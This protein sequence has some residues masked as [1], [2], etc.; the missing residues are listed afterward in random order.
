MPRSPRMESGQ[1]DGRSV[2]PRTSDTRRDGPAE[3]ATHPIQPIPDGV[4]PDRVRLGDERRAAARLDHALAV[5]AA[6]R[7]VQRSAATEGDAAVLV[8]HIVDQLTA[9]GSYRAAWMT[10]HDDA[11]RV[12]YVAQAGFG[13]AFA[14]LRRRLLE[15]DCGGCVAR[16]AAD[17]GPARLTPHDGLCQACP[18]RGVCGECGALT[19]ALVHEGRVMG[20]LT[21]A[22]RAPAEAI[23]EADVLF[24]RLVEDIALALD[25]AETQA[26]QRGTEQ[27]LHE[28]RQLLNAISEISPSLLYVYDFVEDRLRYANRELQAFL[29][30]N[31]EQAALVDLET[32]LELVHPEDRQEAY[33]LLDQLSTLHQGEH[34]KAELRVR[35]SRGGWHWLRIWL[36]VLEAGENGGPRRVL[37]TGVD[38]TEMRLSQERLARQSAEIEA[39]ANNLPDIVTRV[40][41]ALRY[42]FF[43]RRFQEVTGVSRGGLGRTSREVGLPVDLCGLLEKS[44][45]AVFATE[46]AAELDFSYVGV[47]G[48][49]RYHARLVPE[50]GRDGTVDTILLI[51]AD[52]TETRRAQEEIRQ[53]QEF[54]SA[55]VNGLSAQLA[56]LNTRGT[57]VAVNEAWRRFARD[58][59]LEAEHFGIGCNYLEVCRA[60]AETG[61]SELGAAVAGIAAVIAGR[62]AEYSFEY[63]CHRPGQPT[64]AYWFLMRVTH[65]RHAGQTWGV[66]THVDITDRRLAEDEVRKF[67]TVSDSAQYGSVIIDR[68]QRVQYANAALAAMHGW[69][70]DELLH[71]PLSV[72][73]TRAQMDHI[74]LLLAR[75]EREGGFT[76]EEAW[77]KRRDGSV[78]P[79]LVNGT[80]IRDAQGDLQFLSL[81]YL[82]ITERK[83][84]EQELANHREHLEE[85]V[86]RRTRELEGSR[87]ALR[88]AERLASLGTLA[89]GIAHEINNPLAS[90]RL[91]ARVAL[92]ARE[93]PQVQQ[94]ALE[95]IVSETK[96]CG[97]IVKG[98][99]QFA[100]QRPGERWS[101]DLRKVVWQAV[102]VAR[103]HAERERVRV[104]L[105]RA[106]GDGRIHGNPIELQQALVNIIRNAVQASQPGGGVQVRVVPAA[107]EVTV[108]VRDA[109]RG[110]THEEQQMA[111]DPFF[112][113]RAEQG[114]TGMGLSIVHGIITAHRGTIRID[115]VRGRGTTMT[116]TLPRVI[117]RPAADERDA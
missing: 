50:R 2:P 105:E 55:T 21:V 70:V 18:V 79:I 75:L 94:E 14:E 4:V 98:V 72:L 48:A 57:I 95:D 52:V 30:M 11:G 114:G 1:P 115:S 45:R 39:L 36:S 28:S 116:V 117:A 23:P 97:Q 27:A 56:I 61:G 68:E 8:R 108:E 46:A 69:S 100:R 71:Q 19:G 90:I 41:R 111:F 88:D 62:R 5:L 26:T 82:D 22:L 96:R 17:P 91:S 29:G 37:G 40:D 66:I 73:H 12:R 53:S 93:Q 16:L 103:E 49:R 20:T 60:A 112:T 99:L 31:A 78:F 34:L 77:H 43:N 87:K 42:V 109:G 24:A 33:T 86:E 89:A 38:L 51:A 110:M 10:R 65:F 92:G 107:T 7:A 67:K 13:A 59:E 106:E 6:T 74:D 25:R 44:Y 35:D 32:I 64:Q 47:E 76:A 9:T 81:T 113:T 15:G 80:A 63:P 54:L 83:R 104:E 58:N 102:D 101:L 85:L 84:V 3:P